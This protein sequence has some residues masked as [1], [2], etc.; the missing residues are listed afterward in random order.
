[1]QKLRSG[2]LA[3]KLAFSVWHS[4]GELCVCCHPACPYYTTEPI[5]VTRGSL[6][7]TG[8][9]FSRPQPLIIPVSRP[10]FSW[11]HYSRGRSPPTIPVSR[12][13]FSRLP[14]GM[15][16][17]RPHNCKIYGGLRPRHQCGHPACLGGCRLIAVVLRRLLRLRRRRDSLA[18]AAMGDSQT[19]ET[20][21]RRD[22][23][24]R[25]RW[26][27]RILRPNR[28]SSLCEDSACPT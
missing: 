19:T 16:S 6:S 3:Q 13:S 22:S 12:P 11:L 17:T 14:P 1:M 24:A 9:L 10:S 20:H 18:S 7:T 21:A 5:A 27:G 23:D 2:T 25:H 26:L 8:H 15:R 28:K 4:G